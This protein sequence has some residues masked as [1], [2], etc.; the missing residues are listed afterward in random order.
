MIQPLRSVHRYAF[1]ALAV[2]LPIVIVTGLVAHRPRLSGGAPAA[3]LPLSMR[4]VSKSGTLWLKHAV[5]TEFYSDSTR[6]AE[7]YVVLKPTED[8]NEPDLLIYWSPKGS[9]AAS[10]PASARLLGPFATDKPIALPQD[11]GIAGY[12]TLFSLAHQTV[13]DT[14]KLEK[15]P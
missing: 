3:Q 14:A 12:L 8:F 5:Q 11:Q 13:F 15:L 6:P 7:I 2:V 1:V 10:L 9:R 4:L